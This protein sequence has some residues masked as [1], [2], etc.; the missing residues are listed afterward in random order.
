MS[1]TSPLYQVSWWQ[2]YL[3]ILI[4]KHWRKKHLTLQITSYEMTLEFWYIW[5]TIATGRGKQFIGE[6]NSR[7]RQGMNLGQVWSNMGISFHLSLPGEPF[8][9]TPSLAQL[10]GTQIISNLWRGVEPNQNSLLEVLRHKPEP[11]LEQASKEL[12]L[13][14]GN[15]SLLFCARVGEWSWSWC[16]A[17][18][19]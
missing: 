15:F 14:W 18:Q 12:E 17:Y 7:S 3:I 8:P 16:P 6:N 1:L 4:R 11:G 5:R 19:Y 9:R 10:T 2:K 13:S